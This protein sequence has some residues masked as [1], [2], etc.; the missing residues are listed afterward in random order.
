MLLQNEKIN[1]GKHSSN[2][3]ERRKEFPGW[4]LMNQTHISN[5]CWRGKARVYM[6]KKRSLGE[7]NVTEGVFVLEHLEKKYWK[8]CKSDLLFC[9]GLVKG[10]DRAY[11]D[12]NNIICHIYV[13]LCKLDFLNYSEII[14]ILVLFFLLFVIIFPWKYAQR[15]WMITVI[16]NKTRSL[17]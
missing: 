16:D 13:F 11:N 6:S 9:F 4:Q 15:H 17:V 10:V 8:F 5:L 1:Q 14:E 12:G 2:I 3:G 7:K